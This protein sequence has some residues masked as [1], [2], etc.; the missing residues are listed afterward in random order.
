MVLEFATL[1]LAFLSVD[2]TFK[3]QIFDNKGLEPLIRLLCNP[4]ADV[5]KNSV[6]CIYNLVQVRQ[7]LLETAKESVVY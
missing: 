1:G 2:C 3:I 4:D 7:Q 6:E 5:K